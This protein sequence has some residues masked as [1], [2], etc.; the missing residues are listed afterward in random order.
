M[1]IDSIAGLP[2]MKREGWER[3]PSKKILPHLSHV[4]IQIWYKEFEMSR[5]EEI[6]DGL[7]VARQRILDAVSDLSPDKHDQVFLGTWSIKD[8]LAHLV[9]WDVT[10]ID[11][12]TDIRAGHPPHVF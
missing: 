7:I 4:I 6:I 3:P 12:V 10:N 5:K 11:A 9:G 1:T 8:M 2:N